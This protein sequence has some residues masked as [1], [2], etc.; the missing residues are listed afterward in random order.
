MGGFNCY[1]TTLVN[2][3]GLVEQKRKGGAWFVVSGRLQVRLQEPRRPPRLLRVSPRLFRNKR[4]PSCQPAVQSSTSL[5]P[6]RPPESQSG[7]LL[8]MPPLL[9]PPPPLPR[10]KACPTGQFLFDQRLPRPL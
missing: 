6:P 5:Q 9:G 8:P 4:L 3:L 1:S 10:Q 7:A 2:H